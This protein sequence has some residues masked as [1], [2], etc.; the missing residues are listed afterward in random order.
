MEVDPNGNIFRYPESIKGDRHLRDW[1]LIN[2]IVI[3]RYYKEIF[4]VA[5]TW[6]H[7]LESLL[8]R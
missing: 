2:L 6:R 5:K 7:K 1:R 8:D 3:E 4:E